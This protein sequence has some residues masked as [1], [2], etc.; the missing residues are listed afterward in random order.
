MNCTYSLVAPRHYK[1]KLTFL[2]LDIQDADCS[3]DRI[4]LYNGRQLIP[5]KKF[6]DICNGTHTTELIS[7]GRHMIMK[8]IGNTLHTYRGFHVSLLFI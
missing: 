2:Y 3:T 4:E 1:V 6:A 7:R 5:N 8:F